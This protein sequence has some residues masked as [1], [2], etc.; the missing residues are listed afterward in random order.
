M[1]RSN[2]INKLLKQFAEIFIQNPNFEPDANFFY[3]TLMNYGL[4]EKEYEKKNI[5]YM[6][7]DWTM[8]FKNNENC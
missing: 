3:T 1:D 5:T 6:F 8:Y 4:S 2:Q 7:D